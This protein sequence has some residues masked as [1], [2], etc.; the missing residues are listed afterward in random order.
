[1]SKKVPFTTRVCILVIALKSSVLSYIICVYCIIVGLTKE[2]I[3]LVYG[4]LKSKAKELCGRGPAKDRRS[5]EIQVE[6]NASSGLY[7]MAVYSYDSKCDKLDSK[8]VIQDKT[9]S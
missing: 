7:I 1:M 3:E 4:H 6:Q 5:K 9:I 8:N 2:S